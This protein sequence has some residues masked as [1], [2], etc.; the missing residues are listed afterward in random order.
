MARLD[1]DQDDSGFRAT[2]DLIAR[3]NREFEESI[4]R[5]LATVDDSIVGTNR[6]ELKALRSQPGRS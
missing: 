4:E 5:E 3:V 6:E 1:D 2:Q